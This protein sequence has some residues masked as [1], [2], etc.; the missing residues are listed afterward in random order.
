LTVIKDRLLNQEIEIKYHV[1]D[2]LEF[3][4]HEQEKNGPV[5]Y[6]L[7]DILSFADFDYLHAIVKETAVNENF[8]VGRSFM[9]NRLSNDQLSLLTRFGNV[10][11][12]D[13]EES[14]GMYQVFSLKHRSLHAD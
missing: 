7:S 9:R 12:H 2:L 14:T 11:L 6:S 3:L 13:E 1:A 8:L 5:F 10:S 4:R